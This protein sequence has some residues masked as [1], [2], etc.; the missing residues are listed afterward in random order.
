MQKQKYTSGVLSQLA[1][2]LKARAEKSG[3]TYPQLVKSAYES[4][5][6]MTEHS[7]QTSTSASGPSISSTSSS[8]STGRRGRQTMENKI[9]NCVRELNTNYT[10]NQVVSEDLKI[11]NTRAEIVNCLTKCF[12]VCQ[13]SI[14]LPQSDRSRL[15]KQIAEYFDTNQQESIWSYAKN[16]ANIKSFVD[17]LCENGILQFGYGSF[18]K[19]NHWY[20]VMSKYPGIQRINCGFTDLS[21]FLGD[22][23]LLQALE[24][25]CRGNPDSPFKQPVDIEK[26]VETQDDET[27]ALETSTPSLDEDEANSDNDSTLNSD[28]RTVSRQDTRSKMNKQLRSE[29]NRDDDDVER[30]TENIQP[31]Q[32][33]DKRS[34]DDDDDGDDDDEYDGNNNK[35]G[36]KAG[37]ISQDSDDVTSSNRHVK[38]SMSK[39]VRGSM[40]DESDGEMSSQDATSNRKA[41]EQSAHENNDKTVSRKRKKASRRQTRSD[42]ESSTSSDSDA[43]DIKSKKT[44]TL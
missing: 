15:T 16:S 43:D 33:R 27:D 21:R 31:K 42:S 29:D 26:V 10:L 2:E 4:L 34:N 11:I 35:S 38:S 36:R 6:V 3:Q 25:I 37:K 24:R 17:A 30:E 20:E 22:K 7:T 32:R 41:T 44:K 18:L 23:V 19:A 12:Q 13:N 28:E 9:Q 14:F 40:S 39:K 8:S 1:I 5:L